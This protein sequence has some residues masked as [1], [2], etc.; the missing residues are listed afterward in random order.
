MSQFTEQQVLEALSNVIDPDLNQDL[1]TLKMIKDIVI[2]DNKLVFSVELTTPACP[3]KEQIKKACQNAIY[4]FINQDIELV[5]HM[6]ARVSQKKGSKELLPNVKNIIAIS[7]GKGGVGKSTITSNIAIALSKLGAKVGIIDADIY[8][9]SIPTMFDVENEKPTLVTVDGVSL[10]QPVE[11]YGIKL[12]SIGFFAQTKQ[13]IVWRGPMATKAINQMLK[14]T[15][16]GSLDYLLI[17][18]PPGTGDIHLTIVGAL[19]LTGAIIV[20]TPQKIALVDARKGLDMFQLPQ[21]N[22][23][24]IGVIENMSYFTPA[25]LPDNKYYIFGKD[26]AKYLAEDNNVPFLGEIPIVQSICEASDIGRPVAL[27]E[28][29]VLNEV[30]E[31]IAM[32]VAQQ[33]SIA[34]FKPSPVE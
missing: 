27:Q 33:I 24:I 16:W 15:D 2:D 17:D 18:L 4:H 1:V 14:D 11:S 19:K 29:G 13:A 30:F 26:G 10:M 6:T 23:P 8:G 34:N 7:S 12:L 28:K 9:P 20:S 22:V 21:I 32:K 25:E 5:I 3:M 31:S